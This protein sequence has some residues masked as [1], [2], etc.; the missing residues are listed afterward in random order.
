[1]EYFVVWHQQSQIFWRSSHSLAVGWNR[2]WAGTVAATEK[3]G[4]N[5]SGN[6]LQHLSKTCLRLSTSILPQFATSVHT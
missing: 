4:E 1:M 3:I 6:N 5:G 2:R